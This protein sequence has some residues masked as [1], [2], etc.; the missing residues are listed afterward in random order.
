[1]ASFVDT[2]AYQLLDCLA[3]KL[4]KREGTV[5]SK[6]SPC[7]SHKDTS[8]RPNIHILPQLRLPSAE[9]CLWSSFNADGW[10]TFFLLSFMVGGG[11]FPT[12]CLGPSFPGYLERL[13][14][15][16]WLWMPLNVVSCSEVAVD[17]QWLGHVRGVDD[18]NG[19]VRQEERGS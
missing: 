17:S 4:V 9:M 11:C 3:S 10:L 14:P 5:F 18:P 6:D 1:M 8:K 13:M 19:Q 12:M 2:A 16:C 15:G 7:L